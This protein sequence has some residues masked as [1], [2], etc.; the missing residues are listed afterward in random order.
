MSTIIPGALLVALVLAQAE[1]LLRSLWAWW[2]A[3]G[4]RR[5][6]ADALKFCACSPVFVP[7]AG[8]MLVLHGAGCPVRVRLEE[9]RTA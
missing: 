3:R 1:A 8:R 6:L 9:A 5:W 2:G 7:M 4:A